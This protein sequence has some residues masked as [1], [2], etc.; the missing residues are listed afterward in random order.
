MLRHYTVILLFCITTYQQQVY[1]EYNQGT[2]HISKPYN[3][4]ELL[5]NIL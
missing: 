1:V 4:A 5:Q 2:D 3:M